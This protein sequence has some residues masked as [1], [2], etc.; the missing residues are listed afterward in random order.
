V[1]DPI[2]VPDLSHYQPLLTPDR[3]HQAAAVVAGFMFKATQGTGFTDPNVA[4]S[5][6]GARSAGLPFGTYHFCDGEDPWAQVQHYLA[7]TPKDATWLCLDWETNNAG[8]DATRAQV[9]AMV[10]LIRKADPRPLAVY[11]GN[12]ARSHGGYIPDVPAWVPAY[13]GWTLADAYRPTTAP[14]VAWQYTNGRTNG[15]AMP[16]SIP[17]IGPCDVSTIYRPDL[18][19]LTPSEEDVNIDDYIAGQAAYRDA[20]QKKGED[21]G[22]PPDGKSRYFNAGW[23]SERFGA[24]NPKG[25]ATGGMTR[26]DADAAY[27]AKGHGHSIKG[28]TV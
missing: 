22:T 9:L 3:A 16:S 17:G 12:Y 13:G 27:A 15:T 28:Q 7:V 23:S 2:L 11:S 20:F 25:S 8:P 6:S 21:P 5:C 10:A 19:G 24:N 26:A 4:G 18:I 14:L 1:A